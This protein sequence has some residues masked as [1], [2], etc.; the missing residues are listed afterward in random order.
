MSAVVEGAASRVETLVA[1]FRSKWGS[2]KIDVGAG[3]YPRGEEFIT[4][5][6][7]HEGAMV[8]AE[9]WELPFKDGG[10]DEIWCSHA[11]E[12]VSMAQ[13]SPTLK[14]FLRVLKVGGRL[15]LTVPDMDYIAK[16]WLL[17]Q[18]RSWAEKMIFGQQNHAGEF[19]KCGFNAELLQGDLRGCGFEIKV[20][21][22]VQSHSQQGLQAVAIKPAPKAE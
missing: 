1:E 11:L 22:V 4:V 12:H 16:Y 6:K 7:H 17:G 18:D 15:I 19:H 8:R 2:V 21:K 9:M 20:L 10:V 14:D 3:D 5:D 13:V